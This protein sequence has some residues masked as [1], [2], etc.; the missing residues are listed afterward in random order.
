[1]SPQTSAIRTGASEEGREKRTR[2]SHCLSVP[3]SYASVHLHVYRKGRLK[4]HA[5]I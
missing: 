1:M 3:E 2:I 5:V 4:L